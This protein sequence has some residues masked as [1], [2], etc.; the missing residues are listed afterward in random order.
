MREVKI[1]LEGY[2]LLDVLECTLFQ[3]M[4]EHSKARICGHI[5][6]IDEMKVK[7]LGMHNSTAKI[8]GKQENGSEFILFNGVIAT[9]MI[10][11][12]DGQKR[13]EMELYDHTYEMDIVEKIRSIQNI[14]STYK[15]IVDNILEDYDGAVGDVPLK[16]E[17]KIEEYLV[18]YNETDWEFIKRLAARIGTCIFT[19]ITYNGIK[20]YMGVPQLNNDKRIEALEYGFGKNKECKFCYVKSRDYLSLG[21]RVEFQGKEYI[22]TKVE[23]T[24]I[25]GEL[26]HTYKLVKEM[27]IVNDE[28]DNNKIA[29]ISL[30]GTVDDVKEDTV[31]IKLDQEV[32]EG[33]LLWFPYATIYSSPDR[34]GW[35]C[36][37]EINDSVRLYFPD[38]VEKNAYVLSSVHVGFEDAN[39]K[40]K[41]IRSRADKQI[42]FTDTMLKITNNKGMSIEIID[43]DG[44]Y[45]KSNEKIALEADKG[46]SV[47]SNNDA[48]KIVAKEQVLLKQNESFINIKNDVI[49]DG[50]TV[51]MK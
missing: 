10:K 26:Y 21:C 33:E 29:G 44:I 13:L 17:N 19:D 37:P 5:A 39:P 46:I 45:I 12:T 6:D 42:L 14:N 23:T 16:G 32:L 15:A 35:Y 47:V 22:N 8:I 28:Y 43:D 34:T 9:W 24:L 3:C 51:Q 41:S 4:N 50:G 49:I 27:D 40:E 31:K 7:E 20:F 25:G 2:P 36:M 38:A 30:V 18:Q 11:N 1:E 48:V